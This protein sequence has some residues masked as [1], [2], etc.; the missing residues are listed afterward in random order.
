MRR[1]EARPGPVIAVAIFVS[2][3]AL[4]SAT[5]ARTIGLV[6]GGEL[7]VAA[8]SAGNAHPPGF[9]LYLMLAHVATW[10]P[11]G[12]I[13]LRTNL[14]S[15][16]CAA[17][18][19]GVTVLAAAEALALREKPGE[20]LARGAILFA[21]GALLACSRTLWGYATLTEV[22]AL[23]TALLATVVWLALGW[24]RRKE[25]SRLVGAA[26]VFGLALGV[27]YVTVGLCVA[28]LAVLAASGGAPRRRTVGIAAAC[29]LAGLVA[30]AYLPIAA[31]REPVLNWGDPDS[32]GRFWRH[33]SGQQYRYHFAWSADESARQIGRALR[34]LSRELAPPWLPIAL[35]LAAWGLARLYRADRAVFTFLTLVIAA[36]LGFIL[37]YP[38]VNDQDAYL[39]PTVLALVVAAAAGM[40]AAVSAVRTPRARNVAAV[41]MTT[42]PLIA[43]ATA[44]PYRDR[45]G[46]TVASDYVGNAFRVMEPGALLITGDWQLFGP[47][48]YATEVEKTRRDVVPVLTGFL[49]RP[50]YLDDLRRRHPG[51]HEG[52]RAAIEAYRPWIERFETNRDAYM[53]NQEWQSQLNDRLDDLLLSMIADHIRR[54]PVYTTFDV[55]LSAKPRDRKLVARLRQAYDVLPRGVVVQLLPG[56]ARRSL[57]PLDLELRGLVDGSIAYDPDDVV[58]TEVLPVYRAAFEMRAAYLRMLGDEAGAR[59][60]VRK[61]AELTR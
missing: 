12:S 39:L 7:T 25:A 42:L 3:L 28:G 16:I 13:A 43:C 14:F 47:M 36:N 51:L 38:V 29:A 48:L 4:Y 20:G 26:A 44:W 33:V 37:V 2:S 58:P 24:H 15:A 11:A 49:L 23:N 8:W 5:A 1:F 9:P 56:H 10:I 45:S 54:G 55:A 57:P 34:Y 53:R 17:T 27:H 61:A 52:S 32:L 31:S 6:D 19:S 30:Y 50:W 18:A 46:F 59:E 40:Q 21:T 22:Y 41:A 35:A 60:A